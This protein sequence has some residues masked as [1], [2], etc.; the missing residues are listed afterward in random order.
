MQFDD[1]IDPWRPVSHRP[2]LADHRQQQSLTNT[3]APSSINGIIRSARRATTVACTRG[4]F[5]HDG[6]WRR[7]RQRVGD[8]PGQ[9]RDGDGTWQAGTTRR[10]S[11]AHVKPDGH[12]WF[13]RR[14]KLPKRSQRSVENVPNWPFSEISTQNDPDLKIF[15][16]VTLLTPGARVPC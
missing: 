7:R 4:R 15:H 9:R 1:P 14:A 3:P 16:K 6:G 11:R 2:P 8:V 12:C 13:V 10:A 5:T